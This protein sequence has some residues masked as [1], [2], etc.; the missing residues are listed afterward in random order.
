MM[1]ERDFTI[2]KILSEN[3]LESYDT[4]AKD[5]GLTGNAVRNRV[6]EMIDRGI[7][8]RLCLCPNPAVL[9]YFVIVAIFEHTEGVDVFREFNKIENV[10]FLVEAINGVGAVVLLFREEEDWRREVESIFTSIPSAKLISAFVYK[11]PVPNV[12]IGKTDWEIINLLKSDAREK[13]CDIAVQLNFSTKTIKRHLDKL[14]DKE[15]VC[16][17]VITQPMKMEGAIPYY[18]FI[19]FEDDAKMRGFGEIFDRCWFK[20]KIC[21]IPVFIMQLYSFSFEEMWNT[22]RFLQSANGV[23]NLVYFLP[24]RTYFSDW[25]VHEA[26]KKTTEIIAIK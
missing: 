19:E 13:M 17:A 8:E 14:I 2:L 10:M 12:K 26:L 21:D 9:G 23:K 5:V 25:Y 1:D 15:V 6:Q 3:V 18:L 11:R 16:S 7:I 20:Q 24:Y 4:I 22:I